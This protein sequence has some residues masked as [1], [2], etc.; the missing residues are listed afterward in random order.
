M[1]PLLQQSVEPVADSITNLPDWWT[2]G[3]CPPSVDATEWAV[4]L[5]DLSAPMVIVDGPAIARGGSW[6]SGVRPVDARRVI[7]TVPRVMPEQLGDPCFRA[8]HRLRYAYVAGA[9]ANGIASA[10]YA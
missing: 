8:D 6:A 4:Q 3:D 7:A 2:P 10:T 1:N 5:H 9:M